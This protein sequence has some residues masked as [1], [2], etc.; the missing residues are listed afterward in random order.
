M[1]AASSNSAFV[2]GFRA[3][4]PFLVVVLPFAMLFGVVATEAGLNL[5]EVMGF[6]LLVIAGAAQFAAVQ[7]MVENAPVVIVLASALVV[8]LRMAMYSAALAP[9]LGEAP[10]WKRALIA[11]LNVDQTFALSHAEYEAAPKT[12]IGEKVAFFFGAAVPICTTWYSFTWVGAVVGEAIPP[13][14]ALDFAVPVTFLAIVGPALR[15]VA[16]VAAAGTAV[17]LALLLA[18]LPYNFGLMFSALGAMAVGAE[19]ERRLGG[20]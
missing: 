19:I 5:A 20:V 6:S 9:H 7:L 15:T 11:Y 4:L 10:I 3:A 16:H 12:P 18:G 8:N 14:W 17:A 13:E 2:R 1:P